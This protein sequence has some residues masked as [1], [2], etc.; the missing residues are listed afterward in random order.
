MDVD[1][2]NIFLQEIERIKA[3]R[4]LTWDDKAEIAILQGR[5][6]CSKGWSTREQFAFFGE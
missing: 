1:I 5:Y 6:A 2:G 3:K 4:V